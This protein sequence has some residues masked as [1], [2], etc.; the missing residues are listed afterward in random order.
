MK[1][2]SLALLTV[3]AVLQT[4][5]SKEPVEY[6]AGNKVGESADFGLFK[7]GYHVVTVHGYVDDLAVCLILKDTMEKDGP[8]AIYECRPLNR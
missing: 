1:R 4:G 3:V 8:R 5:C 7:N 6:F 2:R